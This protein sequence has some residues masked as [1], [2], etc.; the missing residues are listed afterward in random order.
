MK[1]DELE[2]FRL[3]FS[4]C[5]NFDVVPL[6]TRQKKLHKLIARN[7]SRE[8][9]KITLSEILMSVFVTS[10]HNFLFAYMIMCRRPPDSNRPMMASSID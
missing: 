3:N 7:N 2:K 10:L 8:S 5:A 6:S 9:V 1:N 4:I